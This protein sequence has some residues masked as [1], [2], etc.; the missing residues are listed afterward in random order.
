MN[1]DPYLPLSGDARCAWEA[2]GREALAF[3]TGDN[4]PVCLMIGLL[5][6]S[7]GPA[8]TILREHT[9]L[10]AERVRIILKDWEPAAEETLLNLAIV[11]E[12]AQAIAHRRK[13]TAITPED[14]LLVLVDAQN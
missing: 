5:E 12:R 13:A 10:T 9:N 1:T 14:L 3:G 11:R 7:E 6:L 4:G 8:A 2:G